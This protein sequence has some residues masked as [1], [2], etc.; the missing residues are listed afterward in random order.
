MPPEPYPLFLSVQVCNYQ[1]IVSHE[2]PKLE[3]FTLCIL[4][5]SAPP[6]APPFLYNMYILL[7]WL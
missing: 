2:T 5:V 6:P 1:C 3:D 7:L 4:Q